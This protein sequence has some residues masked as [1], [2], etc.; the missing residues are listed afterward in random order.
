[1]N[2]WSSPRLAPMPNLREQARCGDTSPIGDLYRF[3]LWAGD[4]GN[5]NSVEE[6]TF[7][8][9]IW[10]EDDSGNEVDVYDNGVDQPIENGSIVIHTE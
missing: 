8:I 6:D 4:V 7:R 10:Y 9:R 1:M 5:T 2:G 3:M